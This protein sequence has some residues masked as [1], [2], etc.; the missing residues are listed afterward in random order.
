IKKVND[1]LSFHI[2]K[3]NVEKLI[4]PVTSEFMPIQMVISEETAQ[5]SSSISGYNIISVSVKDDTPDDILH[6]IDNSIYSIAASVQGGMLGSTV[7]EATENKLLKNYTGLLSDTVI[8]FCI[9]SVI[10][11]INLSTYINWEN[12]KHEYGVLRSFG[13]S[14]H[15]LQHKLFMQ[16]TISIL[17]STVVASL[18]GYLAFPGKYG[19]TFGQVAVSLLISLILTYFCRV[20]LYFIYK[21]QTISSMVNETQ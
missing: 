3:F 1:E 20:I 5:K 6:E 10:I 19:M 12:N 9:M 16:F 18:L 13:M 15:T 7:K 4:T 8:I 11:Y 21:K 17:C 14:Y 2:E